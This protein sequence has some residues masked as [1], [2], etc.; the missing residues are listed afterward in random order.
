M[1]E[2]EDA[3]DDG[4]SEE[5]DII[6]NGD[7]EDNSEDEVVDTEDVDETEK[8]VMMTVK[9]KIMTIMRMRILRKKTQK[10]IQKMKSTITRKSILIMKK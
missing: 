3:E 6:D 2:Q 4:S 10:T 8:V 7:I 9:K 1:E 5:S